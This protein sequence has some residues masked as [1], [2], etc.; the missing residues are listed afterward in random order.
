MAITTTKKRTKGD[1]DEATPQAGSKAAPTPSGRTPK[2]TASGPAAKATAT[3]RATTPKAPSGMGGGSAKPAASRKAA[4]S[5]R[6]ASTS[7]HRLLERGRSEGFITHDQILE[8]VPQPEEHRRRDRGTRT[9]P[10]RSKASRSWTP[11]PADT[12]RG[13]GYP[14]RRQEGRRQG[15]GRRGPGGAGRRPDRD[16]RPGSDVPQ[17][18][19]QGRAADRGG[20]GRPGQGH[21]AR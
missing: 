7:L 4:A 14:A 9:R 8:A 12:D 18:D 17:G 1:D 19:R 15:R 6:K 2:A 13:A 11:K 16:R 10:P 5:G 20:G 3:P 21:R